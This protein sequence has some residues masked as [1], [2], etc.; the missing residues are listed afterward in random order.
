MTT[1]FDRK[2]EAVRNV[3]MQNS[4]EGLLFT[5]QKNVS[6]LTGARSFINSASEKSIAAILVT[7]DKVILIVNNIESNRMIE[8]EIQ[9]TIDIVETFPWYEPEKSTNIIQKY[10][11]LLAMKVDLELEN[12]LL[13]LRL[14]VLE[15]EK[16]SLFLLGRQTAEAIEQTAF[17][18]AIGD[19]EFEVASY[20]AREC[21]KR[22]IEPIV[23]LVAADDRIYQ[24]RHPLPT[25]KKLQQY[26]LLVV[27]G[28]RKGVF[29]S[30]S[31]LVHFGKLSYELIDLHR[32]VAT[33]DA[34]MIAATTS[35]V[36]SQELFN[37]MQDAYQTEGYPDEW[38]F[39]H[40]GGLSG[41][42]S[43]EQLLLPSDP[44]F[45]VKTSQVYAWNPS[46]AGV[47]SEDTIFIEGSSPT[48]ISYTGQ[49]PMIEVNL[50]NQLWKRPAILV[51]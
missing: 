12:E 18:L 25:S 15:E 50:G 45:E 19:S 47:K 42:H 43:R 11:D 3:L 29:V 9:G 51:R 1:I 14:T 20:L 35:G 23:N 2:V 38:K 36:H 4:I 28:R 21:L 48:I 8:E 26:A 44:S 46:L 7:S 17:N 41:Y 39:H 34:K 13:Q 40:Q 30:V 10:T 31:R 49:F 22:E 33:I 6:W 32:S 24:R 16:D 27:C 5:L 37:V